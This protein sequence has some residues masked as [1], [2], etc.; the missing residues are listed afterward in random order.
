MLMFFRDKRPIYRTLEGWALGLLVEAGAVRRCEQHGW[1]MDRA[2]PD[3]WQRAIEIAQEHPPLG[4]I[5]PA[6]VAAL[7]EIR[8]SIGDTCPECN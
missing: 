2:D 1:V 5:S 3:S 8:S 4:V 7:E 6:A